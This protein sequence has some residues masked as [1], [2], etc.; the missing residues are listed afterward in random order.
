MP[1]LLRIL[2]ILLVLS[3]V[4]SGLG[5]DPLTMVVPGVGPYTL[6]VILAMVLLL[7]LFRVLR[8]F[9]GCLYTTLEHLEASRNR[10]RMARTGVEDLTAKA[11]QLTEEVR[12]LWQVMTQHELLLP[13]RLLLMQRRFEDAV[14]VLQEAVGSHSN[15]REARWLLGEALFGAKRYADALP[16]LLAGLSEH[17]EHRLAL[18][19]QCEQTLGRFAEAETHLLRLIDVRGE[20]RQDDLVALGAVQ[21]ELEP[22]R[23]R[24]TLTQALELNPF[25]SVA[26]YQLIELEMRTGAYEHAIDL[27]TEGLQRNPADVGCFVSRAEAY[28]RRGHA[29]DDA[30]ILDDL[31]TAQERNRKDYNI[32]RLRG[33]LFQRRASRLSTPAE[34]QR[35]LQDALHAYEEGL[36]NVPPK[37]HAHLLAAE[38][39]VLLQLKRF[40]DAA[41]R[42]QR[43]VN[44]YPGH[45]SNHLALAFARLAARQWKAAAQAAER[46]TQWAGWGGR[47]WLTAIG[48]FANTFAGEEATTLRHKCAALA[49]DLKADVR[50]FALS[51]NWSVVREVLHDAA[52]RA[53]DTSGALVTDTIALLEQAMT[54][55][56][57][58]QRWAEPSGAE[59]RGA[60]SQVADDAG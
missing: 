10:E 47:I 34:G 36:A 52:H 30:M 59:A 41:T 6:P 42:A 4:A 17:D 49:E 29:D 7:G 16:H 19:A 40:D 2:F 44:H 35:A 46:G 50:R 27:A 53:A 3:I 8:Q 24:G 22:T 25:N 11:T 20:A 31:A 5:Y 51:E 32:Y 54:P 39:R 12:E 14:K 45:V 15:N 56:D 57:Y 48:I 21:S 60:A 33:A 37:F 28:F 43:A 38:S 26:R 58:Q 13:G 18:V 1:L 23:A 55:E 9:E